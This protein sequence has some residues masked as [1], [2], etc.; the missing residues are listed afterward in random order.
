[1]DS[2]PSAKD[3]YQQTTNI[4]KDKLAIEITQWK[5]IILLKIEMA[6]TMGEYNTFI[7]IPIP[8][9]KERRDLFRTVLREFIASKGYI[10]IPTKGGFCLD[11][12]RLA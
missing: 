12:S 6:I 2:L 8:Y 10:M 5:Q 11:W 9:T 4:L 1:M 7:A 3:A